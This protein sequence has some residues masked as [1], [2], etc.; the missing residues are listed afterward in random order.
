VS[1]KSL[2]MALWA[3]GLAL[4]QVSFWTS[5]TADGVMEDSPSD[6]SGADT[7]WGLR[8]S[9]KPAP[10][11][12]ETHPVGSRHHLACASASKSM[13]LPPVLQKA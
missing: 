9:D 7:S 12:L 4:A 10:A 13:G 3:N 2:C 8:V 6:S 1:R 11:C 5:G